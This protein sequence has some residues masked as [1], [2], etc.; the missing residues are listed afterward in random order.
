MVLSD[1]GEATFEIDTADRVYVG[2]NAEVIDHPGNATRLELGRRPQAA[3]SRTVGDH[4]FEYEEGSKRDFAIFVPGTNPLRAT[5][6]V[7]DTGTEIIG[8]ATVHGNL[9]LDGASLK[10]ASAIELPTADTENDPA[11]YRAQAQDGDELRIDL[12][13]IAVAD[14]RLVLGVSKDGKFHAALEISYP[15]R[16]TSSKPSPYVH[17]FGDLR[18]DG[19]IKSSDVRTRTVTEEVAALLAG[20][21]QAGQASGS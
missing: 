1:T 5:I 15:T 8:G 13:A 17:V 7:Y 3:D 12:G 14:R 20:M 19:V 21:V 11:I 16:D 4:E 9:V 10:F 6:G 2:L 18:I